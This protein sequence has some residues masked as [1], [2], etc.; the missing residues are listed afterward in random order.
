VAAVPP[1]ELLEVRQLARSEVDRVSRDLPYRPRARHVERLAEQD[2]GEAAYLVAW[3]GDVAVGHVHVRFLAARRSTQARREG[4][5]ELE[6]VFVAPAY[7]RRGA[8]RILLQAAEA[9]AITRGESL[10]GLAVEAANEPARHLYVG[11]GYRE[12]GRGPFDLSY[13]AW[14]DDGVPKRL[15]AAHLYLTKRAGAPPPAI[16]RWLPAYDVA[17]RHEREVALPPEQALVHALTSPAAF[18]RTVRALVALRGMR[19]A[20]SLE[21]F[22]AAHG[23]VVLERTP[24]QWV[25]GMA[26][27]PWR[28]SGSLLDVRSPEE[29]RAAAAPGTIRAVADF[30]AEPLGAGRS[31]LVTETRVAAAD[32]GARRR[33]AAYWTVVGPFSKLIRRRWLAGLAR[34]L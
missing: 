4:C 20:G 7:R 21:A 16:D 13:T 26:G 3:F 29:W 6:D 34:A 1:P 8:A 27:R 15:T 33:F 12:I 28:P 24:T 22:F 14:G 5:V 2:R 32:A 25:A 17:E 31:L 10:V 18:G 11:A 30:R 9:V 23:F 19:P